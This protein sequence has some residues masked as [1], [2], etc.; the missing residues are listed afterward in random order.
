MLFVNHLLYIIYLHLL[1]VAAWLDQC[2]SKIVYERRMQS[3]VLYVV[4]ITSILGKLA[5]VPVGDT[6]TIPFSMHKQT[7]EHIATPRMVLVTA[8]DGGTSSTATPRSG[9][10]VNKLLYGEWSDLSEN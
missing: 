7:R 4:P 10:R 1:C 6:G 8:I 9:R 2:D 5:L 3:Q